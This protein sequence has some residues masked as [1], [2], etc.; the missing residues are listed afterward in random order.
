MSA[1]G[2]VGSVRALAARCRAVAERIEIVDRAV[3]VGLDDAP[4]VGP[5]ADELRHRATTRAG[6]TRAV[7]AELRSVAMALDRD[8]DRLVEGSDG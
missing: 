2:D 1:L 3:R 8:A 4:W 7:A 5:I 6:I